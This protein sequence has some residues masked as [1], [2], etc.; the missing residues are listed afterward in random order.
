M[1]TR[2]LIQVTLYELGQYAGSDWAAEF[3]ALRA[4]FAAQDPDAIATTDLAGAAK[5]MVIVTDYERIPMTCGMVV[6]H[7]DRELT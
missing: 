3:A 2:K 7:L 1:L 6:R 5:P 4:E